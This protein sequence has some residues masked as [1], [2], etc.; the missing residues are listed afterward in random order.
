[1]GSRFYFF[2]SQESWTCSTGKLD[3]EALALS[4]ILASCLYE[5][6]SVILLLR[7]HIRK[8]HSS[9]SQLAHTKSPRFHFSSSGKLLM[10]LPLTSKIPV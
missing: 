10:I 6:Y 2:W 5:P 8:C 3:L 1:M 7:P 4:I 9:S